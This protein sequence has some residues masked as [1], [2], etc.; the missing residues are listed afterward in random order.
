MMNKVHSDDYELGM[1]RKEA[2][3]YFKGLSYNISR[4]SKEYMGNMSRATNSRLGFEPCLTQ[5]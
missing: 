1:W 3:A 5:M 4:G 2:M